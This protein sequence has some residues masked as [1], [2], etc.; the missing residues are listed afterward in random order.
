MKIKYLFFAVCFLLSTVSAQA[1]LKIGIKGG[2]NYSQLKEDNSL[3]FIDWEAR[4]NFY[5]GVFAEIEI[6]DRLS[7]RGE[8]LYSLE[9][10]EFDDG[11]G[12]QKIDINYLNLPILL[13]LDIIGGVFIDAGIEPGIV[14][15]KNDTYFDKDTELGVL[16]GGGF[17]LGERLIFNLRYVRGL[18]SIY[19]YMATDDNGNS[20]DV[21][22][23]STL[24]QIGA[25]FYIFK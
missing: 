10:G 16:F 15:D 17:R 20:S 22:G 14:I 6:N 1:Q 13:R 23:K 8:G 12:N 7:V 4:T 19:E 9:G 11:N 21:N 18:S 3:G 2:A 5:A 25:E 24:W